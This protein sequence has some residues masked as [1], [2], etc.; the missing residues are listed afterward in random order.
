MNLTNELL[1]M[2]EQD[3]KRGHGDCTA[4]N[5]RILRLIESDRASAQLIA[6]LSQGLAKINPEYAEAVNEALEEVG[7]RA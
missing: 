3:A 5:A 1:E 6:Y 2:W 4:A 7:I